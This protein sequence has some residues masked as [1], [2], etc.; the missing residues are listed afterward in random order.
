M[1][2]RMYELGGEFHDFVD[3]RRRGLEF[4]QARLT[5]RNNLTRGT[6][7]ENYYGDLI[8]NG[9]LGANGSRPAD[10]RKD[11]MNPADPGTPINPRAFLAPGTTQSP[12]YPFLENDL[13]YVKR[14]M[15]WP[16]PSGEL[17]TNPNIT[18]NNFG[19]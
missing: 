4:F 13:E 14:A 3:F 5:K 18:T 19:Y 10:G 16:I 7:T 17:N 11:P 2:E 12:S 9:T 6:G 15:L 8:W 1:D